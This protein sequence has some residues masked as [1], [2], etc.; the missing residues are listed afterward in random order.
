MDIQSSSQPG[1]L[2]IARKSA[3]AHYDLF[4]KRQHLGRIISDTRDS[5]YPPRP[6]II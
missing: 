5:S 2:G 4:E 1:R 6:Q 3:T